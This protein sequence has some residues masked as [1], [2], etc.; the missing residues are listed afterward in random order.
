[1]EYAV[2][3]NLISESRFGAILNEKDPPK[4]KNPMVPPTSIR[5][6]IVSDSVLEIRSHPDFR[7]FRRATV[8]SR[9]SQGIAERDVKVGLRRVLLV[10]AKRLHWLAEQRYQALGGDAGVEIG[11][12]ENGDGED[13]D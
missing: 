7:I 3:Q 10:Q 13:E 4:P 8:I 1:L 12:E 5:S 11:H 9:L 2:H 6:R